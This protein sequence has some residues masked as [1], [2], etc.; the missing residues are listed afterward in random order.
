MPLWVPMALSLVVLP[1]L[2]W[3][4]SWPALIITALLCAAIACGFHFSIEVNEREVILEKTWYRYTYA[5]Y[6]ADK[7][8]KIEYEGDWGMSDN[9]TGIILTLDEEPI[10]LGCSANMELLHSELSQRASE[11][12]PHQPRQ[13]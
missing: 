9:A 6:Q 8:R 11:R 1:L 4:L 7:I 10:E 3:I 2:W 12:L 5:R 13:Q